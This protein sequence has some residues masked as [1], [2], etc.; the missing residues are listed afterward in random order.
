MQLEHWASLFITSAQQCKIPAWCK[1]SPSS[2]SRYLHF[3]LDILLE[4]LRGIPDGHVQWLAGEE[5]QEN[6]ALITVWH[7]LLTVAFASMDGLNLPVQTSNDAEVENGTY[8]G[9]LSKHFVSCVFAFAATGRN[10]MYLDYYMAI[11]S[12]WQGLLLG[13]ISMHREAGMI[14]VLPGPYMRS[15]EHRPQMAIMLLLT[16]HFQKAQR[17]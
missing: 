11:L 10:F 15:S 3:A 2:V 7:P 5:F 14:L 1:F 8:N 16:L 12:S 9:W 17:P 4:T 6:N 13:V